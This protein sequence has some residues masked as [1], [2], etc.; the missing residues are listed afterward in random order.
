MASPKSPMAQVPSWRTK[1]FWLLRSRCTTLGLYSPGDAGGSRAVGSHTRGHLGAGGGSHR[2]ATAPGA[3]MRGR[4]PGTEPGVRCRP[5][6][7]RA[8]AGSAAGSPGGGTWGAGGHPG[9]SGGLGTMRGQGWRW[10][11]AGVRPWRLCIP[12]RALRTPRAPQPCMHNIDTPP[13]P[14]C[15]HAHPCTPTRTPVPPSF[16]PHRPSPHSRPGKAAAPAAPPS[17]TARRPGCPTASPRSRAPSAAVRA[18]PARPPSAGPLP[19]Q[20]P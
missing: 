3:G 19:R 10:S 8:G 14:P 4:G 15:F 6:G 13:P 5:T 7:R 11:S 12:N 2:R 18:P 17:R 1:T 20:K 9:G 16:T